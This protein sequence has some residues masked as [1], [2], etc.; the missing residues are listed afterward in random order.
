ME[1]FFSD[2]DESA[3]DELIAQAEDLVALDHLSSL[4]LSSHLPS[5]LESRFQNLKSFP[6]RFPISS[7]SRLIDQKAEEREGF[8]SK[9]ELGKEDGKREVGLGPKS[10]L[11]KMGKHKGRGGGSSSSNSS[12]SFTE[13]TIFMPQKA[14]PVSENGDPRVKSKRGALPGRSGR[15][16][17]NR[18]LGLGLGSDSSSSPPRKGGCFWCS[19]KKKSHRK[20]KDLDSELDMGMGRGNHEELLSDLGSFSMKERRRVLKEAIK[21][22]ERL[23]KEAEKIVMFAKQAA[24]RMQVYGDNSDDETKAVK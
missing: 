23:S 3:V 5:H 19:P 12:G 10:E 2:T 17:F 20:N 4:N 8:S 22:Q 9:L 15:S 14:N 18:G 24:A 6:P 7:P 13:D 21:E 1:D 11:E 16:G